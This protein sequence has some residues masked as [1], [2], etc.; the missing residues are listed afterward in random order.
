MSIKILSGLAGGNHP[1]RL[2]QPLPRFL[3][4]LSFLVSEIVELVSV[5]FHSV[6]LIS[7]E[8]MVVIA[9]V[10]I[11]AFLVILVL[12]VKLIV[13]TIG[14]I[15]VG[16][17][18]R[19]FTLNLAPPIVLVFSNHFVS[20]SASFGVVVIGGNSHNILWINLDDHGLSSIGIH[21]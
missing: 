17:P 13:S 11:S 14:G 6:I 19:F 10:G 18:T 3:D 4:E 5:W 1:S 20:A 7:T 21:E 15:E 16:I 2:C 8:A 12:I 9:S